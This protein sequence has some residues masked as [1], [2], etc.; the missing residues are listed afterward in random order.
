MLSKR[1]QFHVQQASAV[2]D[3]PARRAAYAHRAV[4]DRGIVR[5]TSTSLSYCEFTSV[6]LS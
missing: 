3:G 6:E 1:T 2:A 4:D 5:L